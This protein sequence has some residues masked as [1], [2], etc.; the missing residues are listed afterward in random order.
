MSGVSSLFNGGGKGGKGA[1]ATKGPPPR[2]QYFFD[3]Q[4]AGAGQMV[5]CTAPR[6]NARSAA[7]SKSDNPPTAVQCCQNTLS[8]D[9]LISAPLWS[10]TQSEK[11]GT[12]PKRD[13]KGW[14]SK[15]PL[16]TGARCS[17]E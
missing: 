11:E 2:L 14:Q 16:K 7:A 12:A 13:T 6:L 10:R 8:K 3:D 4:R 5:Y 1:G 17:L 15:S 9:F